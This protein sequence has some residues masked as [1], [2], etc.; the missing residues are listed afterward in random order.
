MKIAV[1]RVKRKHIAAILSLVEGATAKDVILLAVTLG[2][3]QLARANQ[4]KP[5]VDG[6][7]KTH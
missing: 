2:L 7:V 5:I 4:Q 3:N 1:V 6:V